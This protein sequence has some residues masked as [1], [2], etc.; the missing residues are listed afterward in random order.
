M[1]GRRFR[2]AIHQ[3]APALLDPAANASRIAESGTGSGADLVLTPELALTGY[4]VGDAATSLG[5]RLEVPGTVLDDFERAPDTV[6]GLIELGDDGIPYNAAV[7]LREGRVVFRHRKLYLP[8]YGMFYEGRFFGRGSRIDAF[9]LGGGWRAGI[10]ICEDFWHPGLAYLLAA[11][12]IHILL[13]QAAPAGRGVWE[14]GESGARFATNDAWERIARTTAQL[15][16]IYVALANRVGTEGG[17]VFGGSSLLVGPTGDVLAR[18]PDDEETVITATVSLDEVERARRPF[19]HLR[20]E[21]PWFM[22]REL[23]RCLETAS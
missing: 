1:I 2:L 11:R 16:G 14:G 10:L 17:V 5:I 19:A 21:D 22:V 20:D 7:L 15:Y 4:D 3:F 12:E 18:A 13:V 9:E 23:T 8:T 6:L